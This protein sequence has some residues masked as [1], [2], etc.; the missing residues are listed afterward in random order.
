M[1]PRTKRMLRERHR[2]LDYDLPI[3]REGR[4]GARR[5]LDTRMRA[6]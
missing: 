4:E 5:D 6:P 1:K 3:G 2:L